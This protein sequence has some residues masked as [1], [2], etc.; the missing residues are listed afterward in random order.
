MARRAPRTDRTQAAIVALLRAS[1]FSVHSLAGQAGGCPDLVAGR[2]GVTH[3]I[4]VK[5]GERPPSQRRLTPD[6]VR[7]HRAWLGAPVVILSD[8]DEAAQW[9][10]AIQVVE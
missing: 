2:H 4:E 8:L 6:Q 1:G 5:D 10:T 7:W 9:V 3:L